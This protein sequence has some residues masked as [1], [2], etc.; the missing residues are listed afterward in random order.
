MKYTAFSLH[1]LLIAVMVHFVREIH[2]QGRAVGCI[3]INLSLVTHISLA[4]DQCSIMYF[5]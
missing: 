4:N 1:P 5:D 2:S 3:G